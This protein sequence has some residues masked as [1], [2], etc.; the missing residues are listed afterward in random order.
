MSRPPC[1]HC[2]AEG[3]PGTVAVEG[4]DGFR[5]YAVLCTHC[6]LAW[7]AAEKCIENMID[8]IPEERAPRRQHVNCGP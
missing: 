1:A 6:M 4:R 2:G 5:T 7:L 8:W 3:A